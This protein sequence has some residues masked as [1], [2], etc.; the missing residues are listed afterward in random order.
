MG[1]GRT[2]LRGKARGVFVALAFIALGL[3]VLAPPGYMV[4][5]QPAGQ[6]LAIVI[7]TGHGPLSLVTP[8]P[9]KAPPA[10]SRAD[11]PCAFTGHSAPP[12]PS[13]ADAVAVAVV[14]P[15]LTSD[16]MPAD[17]QPGRGLAAPPPPAQAP[18]SV[19]I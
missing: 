5:R 19:L 8:N 2:D 11:G 10:K 18:P 4:A 6:S 16:R 17:V 13:S 7:C 14:R 3:M 15:A 9:L 1:Q 12:A